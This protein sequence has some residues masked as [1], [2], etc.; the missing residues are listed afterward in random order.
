MLRK[1]FTAFG[2]IELLIPETLITEAEQL[3]LENP[4]EC[5]LRSWAVPAARVEGLLIVLLMQRTDALYSTV[6][7]FLG[8]I[9]ILSLVSPRAYIDYVAKLAYTDATVCEW[10]P[11]VYQG[12]RLTGLFYVII[13]I[14]ELRKD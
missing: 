13:A 3:G 9:G 8:L 5:E 2:I 7:K 6:K 1:I 11:W 10:K 12:T 14:N 4:E